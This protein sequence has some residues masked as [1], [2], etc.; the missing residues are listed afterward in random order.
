MGES[1]TH[2]AWFQR[3]LAKINAI[4]MSPSVPSPPTTLTSTLPPSSA[5]RPR[6]G[7]LVGTIRHPD[8]SLT[9]PTS[10]PSANIFAKGVNS[11]WRS[12]RPTESTPPLCASPFF[13]LQRLRARPLPRQPRFRRLQSYM[14]PHLRPLRLPPRLRLPH[15]CCPLERAC[16]GRTASATT[17]VGD[18]YLAGTPASSFSCRSRCTLCPVSP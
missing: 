5:G 2:D 14:R 17:V 6:T 3:H 13:C 16:L 1:L 10:A 8:R 12:K 7:Y 4:G 18:S 9:A 15:S 11:I